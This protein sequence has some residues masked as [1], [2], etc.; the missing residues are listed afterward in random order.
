MKV[1]EADALLAVGV[2]KTLGIE[3]TPWQEYLLQILF[4]DHRQRPA[5]AD[6]PRAVLCG[7]PSPFDAS[8][9]CGDLAGHSRGQ[10]AAFKSDGS[11][12]IWS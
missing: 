8:V 4:A 1:T 6:R 12:H 3:L 5:D 7:A 2:A 10:H 9:L 11:L